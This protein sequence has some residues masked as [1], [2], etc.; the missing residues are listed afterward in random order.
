VGFAK[1]KTSLLH[2]E[3]HTVESRGTIPLLRWRLEQGPC[4]T[5]SKEV[6]HII[7]AST[8]SKSIPKIFAYQYEIRISQ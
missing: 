2:L 1:L 4:A 7:L 5:E 3:S 6:I 8:K